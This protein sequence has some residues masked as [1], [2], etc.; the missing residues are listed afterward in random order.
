[1]YIQD[2]TQSFF[3]SVQLFMPDIGMIKM[4]S[5]IPLKKKKKKKSGTELTAS[6]LNNNKI[7]NTQEVKENAL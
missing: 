3:A 2:W 1:M 4:F 7:Q 6:V 5:F